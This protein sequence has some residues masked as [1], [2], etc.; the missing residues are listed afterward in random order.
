MKSRGLKHSSTIL[1]RDNDHGGDVHLSSTNG[2]KARD[3]E[4]DRSIQ[5]IPNQKNYRTAM[6]D[7]HVEMSATDIL[8]RHFSGADEWETDDYIHSHGR[9]SEALLYSSLYCP[10]VVEISGSVILNYV[11]NHEE[12][13]ERFKHAKNSS[14]TQLEELEASFNLTEVPYLFRRSEYD[15]SEEEDYV[16]TRVIAEAWRAWLGYKFPGRRFVVEI[17][18]SAETGSTVGLTFYEKRDREPTR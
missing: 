2:K 15:L 17:L 16:F 18:S 4:Q 13:K 11:A 10:E 8:S 7:E 6:S 14:D 5:E 1:L 3:Q 12:A 9:A